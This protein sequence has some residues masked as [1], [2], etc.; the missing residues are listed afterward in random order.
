MQNISLAKLLSVRYIVPER[1]RQWKL[2]IY[3]S[4]LQ[5]TLEGKGSLAY[6]VV[7]LPVHS[8]KARTTIET[9]IFNQHCPNLHL[10]SIQSTRY[11]PM[12]RAA[13]S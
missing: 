4:A 6:A 3:E 11:V 9:P 10:P 5:L 8:R 2:C 7:V 12:G 1:P 13:K